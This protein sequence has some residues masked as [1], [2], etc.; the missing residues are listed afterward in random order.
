MITHR[1]AGITLAIFALILLIFAIP[2]M[3]AGWLTA[4]VN[5]DHVH[6]P[7]LTAAR[8]AQFESAMNIL[9]QA[10]TAKALAAAYL[11]T[12][13]LKTQQ[14][15]IVQNA[16]IRA[17]QIS[18]G[19]PYNWYYLALSLE[20]EI[21]DPA[22]RALF[23]QALTMSLMTGP[24]ERNLVMQ[25]LLM[26]ARHWEQV[27]QPLRDNWEDQIV[28]LWGTSP[29]DLRDLYL[30]MPPD[31]QKRVFATLDE[32]PGESIKFN[33]YLD[34]PDHPPTDPAADDGETN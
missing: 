27:S 11:T 20:S 18:P 34:H 7:D 13:P 10:E 19:D 24:H 15:E 9:P 14:R 8:A 23:D 1:A 25:R 3:A 22:R 32:I 30:A 26:I 6:T 21:F 5:L 17:V 33:Q 16:A 4:P 28:Y 2:Q 31:S 12:G 29:K